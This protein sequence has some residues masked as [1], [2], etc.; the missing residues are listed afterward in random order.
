MFFLG[1]SLRGVVQLILFVVS[2]MLT[3]FVIDKWV[4][5]AVGI[6]CNLVVNDSIISL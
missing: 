6:G 1:R 2:A 4:A 5:C 3:I